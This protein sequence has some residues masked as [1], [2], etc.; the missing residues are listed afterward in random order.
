MFSGEEATYL[1]ANGVNLDK[2]VESGLRYAVEMSNILIARSTLAAQ[3]PT[4][5]ASFPIM[6]LSNIHGLRYDVNDAQY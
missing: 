3:E 4:S 5:K 1:S 6:L 2:N